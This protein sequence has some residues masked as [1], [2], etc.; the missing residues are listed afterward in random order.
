MPLMDLSGCEA[1][2]R[3]HEGIGHTFVQCRQ[4]PRSDV[5][6]FEFIA[7]HALIGGCKHV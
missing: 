1:V 7:R 3:L 2:L 6:H 4:G 5:L